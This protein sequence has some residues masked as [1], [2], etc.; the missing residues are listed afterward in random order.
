[1]INE[2]LI[3]PINSS[4]FSFVKT[5][6]HRIVFSALFRFKLKDVYSSIGWCCWTCFCKVCMDPNGNTTQLKY[7]HSHGDYIATFLFPGAQ[8]PSPPNFSSGCHKN[9]KLFYFYEGLQHQTLTGSHNIQ[10]KQWSVYFP[11]LIL[12]SIFIYPYS[13]SVNSNEVFKQFLLWWT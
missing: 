6:F 7:D 4:S 3:A 1:M 13:Q 2:N 5:N 9:L 11:L 10:I 12:V 8:P